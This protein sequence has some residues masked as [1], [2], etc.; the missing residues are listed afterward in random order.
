MTSQSL[1]T[2]MLL[3]QYINRLMNN[4]DEATLHRKLEVILPQFF[5]DCHPL[6]LKLSGPYAA[7]S[8]PDVN[9]ARTA[10]DQIK[11]GPTRE[12]EGFSLV[13]GWRCTSYHV[14]MSTAPVPPSLTPETALNLA[15]NI[16]R[17][18]LKN[19][20]IR[21]SNGQ[22]GTFSATVDPLLKIVFENSTSALTI[23][24][25]LDGHKVSNSDWKLELCF[26]LPVNLNRSISVI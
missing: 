6:L 17:G 20:K 10:L 16:I 21:D 2:R 26:D 8:F 15:S 22:D 9:F 13:A 25:C 1:E 24:K 3:F 4:C 14:L 12:I 18:A 23:L 7:M 19:S 11:I 5:L